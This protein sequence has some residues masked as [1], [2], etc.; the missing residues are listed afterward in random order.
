M[1]SFDRIKPPERRLLERPA[2]REPQ[3][4]EA[5]ALG[6]AALFSAGRP[7]ATGLVLFGLHCSSCGEVSSVGPRAALRSALPLFLVVPW[8]RHPIFALCPACRRRAWL[9]PQ[10]HG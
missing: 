10:A 3:S 9:R 2:P 6:R 4:P 1:S 5:D 7:A 8:R